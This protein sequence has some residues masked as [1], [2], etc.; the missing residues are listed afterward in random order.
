MTVETADFVLDQE[1][2]DL[3]FYRVSTQSSV[4]QSS[5]I[6]C[7][8][9]VT[10]RDVCWD[11]PIQQVPG[12]ANTIPIDL[13]ETKSLSFDPMIDVWSDYCDFYSYSFSY[14][15][16]PYAGGVSTDMSTIIVA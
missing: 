4:T 11:L 1:I 14:I 10:L 6:E 13:W 3:K 7:T 5:S 16:G 15:S 9:Q 2:W 12:S 8:V